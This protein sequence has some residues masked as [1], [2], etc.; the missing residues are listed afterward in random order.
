MAPFRILNTQYLNITVL[1]TSETPHHLPYLKRHVPIIYTSKALTRQTLVEKYSL[2]SLTV[3]ALTE[4]LTVIH[5]W[6]RNNFFASEMLYTGGELGQSVVGDGVG[7]GVGIGVEVGVGMI[8]VLPATDLHTVGSRPYNTHQRH[9]I[10]TRSAYMDKN[11]PQ[12]REYRRQTCTVHF[13]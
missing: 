3:V 1:S 4:T 13:S 9:C 11:Q 10:S 12:K 2:P 6:R 5:P 8:E 7:L